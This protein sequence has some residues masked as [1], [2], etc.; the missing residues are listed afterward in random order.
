MQ[1][2]ARAWHVDHDLSNAC[3][4]LTLWQV[5]VADNAATISIVSQELV[6]L[7][8][9]INLGLDDRRKHL[10]STILQNFGQSVSRAI[11]LLLFVYVIRLHGR[12]ILQSSD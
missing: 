8:K 3:Q 1:P 4:N 2:I 6:L 9:S 10:C 7:A 5:A 12:C 11:V